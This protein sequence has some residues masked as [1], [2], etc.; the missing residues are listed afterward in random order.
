[1][2]LRASVVIPTYNRPEELKNLLLSLDKQNIPPADFEV[3]VVDNG[4]SLETK[5][6]AESISLAPKLIY[7]METV[8]GAARARNRGIQ[9]AQAEIVIFVDD[10]MIVG[11]SFIEQHLHAHSRFHKDVCILGKIIHKPRWPNKI[12][13]KYLSQ[14]KHQNMPLSNNEGQELG[15]QC[16]YTANISVPKEALINAGGFDEAFPYYGW[17]DIELGFRLQ[18]K[19]IPIIYNPHASGYHHFDT[20]LVDYLKKRYRS[21]KSLG[22]FLSKHPE[23]SK[24]FHIA[25]LSFFA[26]L[27]KVIV[28]MIILLP[29]L[30]IFKI[31]DRL[32]FRVLDAVSNFALYLGLRSSAKK[33]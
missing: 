10:D 25:N 16:F 31:F 7:A 12:I 30:L 5:R 19:G 29:A 20:S 4:D 9:E 24:D 15:Y 28:A 23:A 6:V 3:V 26:I 32:L 13:S 14:S 17:E 22:Y 8:S 11:P 2:A 33:R 18:Q 27:L 21:G 1:M